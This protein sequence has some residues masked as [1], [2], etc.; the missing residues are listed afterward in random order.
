MSKITDTF[1]RH[2]PYYLI[3][4]WGLSMFMISASFLTT[5]LEYPRSPLHQALPEPLSRHA[6][7]GVGLG[8]VIAGVI[9]SP[10]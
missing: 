2:W 1:K 6:L 10:W 4:A 7:L 9:Y 3:E 8:L 5:L